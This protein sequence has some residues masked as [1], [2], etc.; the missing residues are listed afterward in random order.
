MAGGDPVVAVGERRGERPVLLGA[1]GE[2]R[3]R[4]G[5][6]RRAREGEEEGNPAEQWAR[7]LRSRAPLPVAISAWEI[8]GVR[9]SQIGRAHV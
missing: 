3:G 9:W 4:S 1:E 5:D 7:V 2:S 8:S 6:R